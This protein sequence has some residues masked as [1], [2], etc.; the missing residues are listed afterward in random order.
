MPYASYEDYKELYKGE[1][2]DEAQFILY[3]A[4]AGEY[5]E[6][7]TYGRCAATDENEAVKKACC[8]VAEELY[9]QQNQPELVS[10]SIGQW[11]RT[12]APQK[13]REQRIADSARLYLHGTGLL[14][15][16]WRYDKPAR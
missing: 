5:L 12:Y 3:G 8:A 14:W 13:Q 7:L 1:R 2:L 10:H 11:S 6:L 9:S 16:G 15:R 4:K